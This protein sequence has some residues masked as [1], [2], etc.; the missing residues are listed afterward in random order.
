MSDFVGPICYKSCAVCNAG[1]ALDNFSR[2]VGCKYSRRTVCKPCDAAKAAAWRAAN[3]EKGKA[4]REAYAKAH[5]DKVRASVKAWRAANPAKAKAG[6]ASYRERNQEALK[7][8]RAANSTLYRARAKARAESLTEL[9]K[10]GLKEKAREEYQR[11]KGPI[12]EYRRAWRQANLE[13]VR[14]RERK[15]AELRLQKPGALLLAQESDRKKYLRRRARILEQKKIY[16]ALNPDKIAA[17]SLKRRAAKG[18]AF[19][20]W[21]CPEQIASIFREALNQG[22]DVDHVY[23][24]KGKTVS[25]LHVAENLQP[26][27]SVANR[28]KRNK[29]PGFLAHELWDPTGPDVYHEAAP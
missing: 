12:A 29:L 19:S 13:A 21:A 1:K 20:K 18:Q 22:L 6:Q 8:H 24:L 26:M 4:S 15:S 5:P 7:A 10:E 2:Q 3:P 16:R 27:G 11:N 28:R 14:E 17:H 25:G 9:E 23:P